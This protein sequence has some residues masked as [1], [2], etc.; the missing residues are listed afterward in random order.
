[1][2]AVTCLFTNAQSVM[3][4]FPELQAVVRHHSPQIIGL[5][6]SWCS[7]SIDDAELYLNGYN[8]FHD[9]RPFGIGGG[10][11]LYVHSLLS[12]VL[13]KVLSDVGFENS[14]WY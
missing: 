13:C 2:P 5:A 9:D 3:N 1:M 11:L 4:K 10:V 7:I 8:L 6:E 12:P 14:L